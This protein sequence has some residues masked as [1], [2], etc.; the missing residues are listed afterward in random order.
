[1]QMSNLSIGVANQNHLV[2]QLAVSAILGNDFPEDE[3]KLLDGVVIA[4]HD[5]AN[6]SLVKAIALSATSC[7][8]NGNQG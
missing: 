8:G 6:D 1:M 5:I 2:Q 7:L 3:E 4:R